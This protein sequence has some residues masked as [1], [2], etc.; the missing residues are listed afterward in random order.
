[1]FSVVVVDLKRLC[2]TTS[3]TSIVGSCRWRRHFLDE[4]G[5]AVILKFYVVFLLGFLS[6]LTSNDIFSSKDT[7]GGYQPPPLLLGASATSTYKPETKR[8]AR[9]KE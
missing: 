6:V 3:P 2:A 8:K 5:G 4:N 7:F 9:E 1:M